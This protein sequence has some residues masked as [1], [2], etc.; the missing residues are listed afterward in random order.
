MN[1]TTK[2]KSNQINFF[3]LSNVRIGCPISQVKG[4]CN[5][6]AR[7]A[8]QIGISKCWFLGKEKTGLRG[9]KPLGAEKRANNKVD[10]HETPSPGM[11]P[12][13]TLVIGECSHH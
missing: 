3:Q 1:N 11:E 13:V 5:K 12:R 8:D 2:S 10:L 4:S 6:D 9:E 7:I